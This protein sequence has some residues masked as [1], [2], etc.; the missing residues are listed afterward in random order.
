[1]NLSFR[2]GA[3]IAALLG[4]LAL[5]AVGLVLFHRKAQPH[6]VTLTWQAPPP[7]SGI[8]VVGYNIYRRADE[9]PS[10]VKIA[11]NVPGPPYEDGLVTSGRIYFYAATSVDQEG[12]ESRFSTVVRIEIP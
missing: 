11:T 2:R 10:F 1:M 9:S 5:L 8:T 12:R 6:S 3:G 7:V 4:L